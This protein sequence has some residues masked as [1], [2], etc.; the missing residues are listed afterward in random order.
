MGWFVVRNRPQL[1]QKGSQF[2]VLL[3]WGEGKFRVFSSCQVSW[4][5]LSVCQVMMFAPPGEFVHRFELCTKDFTQVPLTISIKYRQGPACICKGDA[6]GD[7][8]MVSKVRVDKSPQVF[9]GSK[10]PQTPKHGPGQGKRERAHLQC[11]LSTVCLQTVWIIQSCYTCYTE[12]GDVLS[13]NTQ[14]VNPRRSDT[15]PQA[16]TSRNS[17]RGTGQKL[18][19]VQKH[20]LWAWR[21]D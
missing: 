4:M 9:L 12:P 7:S 18:H 5:S 1:C 20:M 6:A 17:P 14:P 13:Y 21:W 8:D 16:V 10:A 15:K 3:W 2:G 19:T 11:S